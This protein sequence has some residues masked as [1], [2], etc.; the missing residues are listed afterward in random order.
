MRYALFTS[1][2]NTLV[3]AW[4]AHQGRSFRSVTLYTPTY[5]IKYDTKSTAIQMFN[6][7]KNLYWAKYICTVKARLPHRDR[8]FGAAGSI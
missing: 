3:W 2:Y 6:H 4:L 7:H 8:H 5:S 1:S